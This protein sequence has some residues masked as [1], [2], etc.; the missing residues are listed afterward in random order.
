M[1]AYAALRGKD[2]WGDKTPGYVEQ[3]DTI[4]RMFPDARFVHVIRDGREAAVS[5]REQHWG[6]PSLVTGGIWWRR[7]VRL[8]RRCGGGLGDRYTELRFEDL[9]SDPEATLRRTCAFLELPYAEEMFGYRPSAAVRQP[10][11]GVGLHRHLT[12]PITPGLRRWDENLSRT[13]QRLLEAACGA[14]LVQLGYASRR[15]GPVWR[16]GAVAIGRWDALWSTP[17]F[18]RDRIRPSERMF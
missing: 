7:K 17:R 6:P 18:V 11:F 1:A 14:E 16:A 2:R 13:Q 12:E 9:V 8:G 10:S 5:M 3:L 15:P 4:A